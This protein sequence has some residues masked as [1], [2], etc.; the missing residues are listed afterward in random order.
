MHKKRERM[1]RMLVHRFQ[2]K[3]QYFS[4]EKKGGGGVAQSVECATTG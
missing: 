1:L 3:H 4:P 2:K